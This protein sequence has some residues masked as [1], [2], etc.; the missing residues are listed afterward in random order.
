[1]QSPDARTP[2]V[3]PRVLTLL[4]ERVGSGGVQEVGDHPLPGGTN[5]EDLVEG[6]L[7]CSKV[8]PSDSLV[9]GRVVMP[10]R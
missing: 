5:G 1:M 9:W 6:R 3:S 2:V 7:A 8:A 4:R 10:H